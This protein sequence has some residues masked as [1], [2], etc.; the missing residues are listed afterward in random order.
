MADPQEAPL[1]AVRG[2]PLPAADEPKTLAVNPQTGEI[3]GVLDPTAGISNCPIAERE[4]AILTAPVDPEHEMEVKYDG[5]VYMP[6]ACLRKRLLDAFGPG[7]WAMKLESPI[8]YDRETSEIVVDYSLWIKG[9]Y[10]SRA[11]AGWTWNPANPRMAKSDSIESAQ[12]EC[13]R[14]LCKN[15]GVGLELWMPGV[16][17]AWR[18]KY[19][20]S[21]KDTKG[22][23][24]WKR[25]DVAAT[26]RS[27]ELKN[28]LGA[29]FDAD[30]RPAT[31][32]EVASAT[33]GGAAEEK[34]GAVSTRGREDAPGGPDNAAPPSAEPVCP[35]CN[36][37][38]WDNRAKRAEAEAAIAAG[39][40]ELNAKGKP[41]AA[42]PGWKCKDKA[43][44]G[45]I[46]TA[47]PE[48][49]SGAAGIVPT[50]DARPDVDGRPE[51]SPATPDLP[52]Q[53]SQ[54]QIDKLHAIYEK[55]G[56]KGPQ[57]LKIIGSRFKIPAKIVH[58]W[59]KAHPK[60]SI[61][62]I[63]TAEQADALIASYAPMEAKTEDVS[64]LIADIENWMFDGKIS[65]E[66]VDEKCTE[67]GIGHP[68]Q[69]SP[70]N[71]IRLL[72]EKCAI[73]AKDGKWK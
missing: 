49:K 22:R 37:P 25:K 68:W 17:N 32:P 51:P 41:K 62:G 46:W 8:V 56:L 29:R 38:M 7:R 69:K 52:S 35:K 18:D 12:T 1:P 57:V 70:A 30:A 9:C 31:G 36:G 43:C 64:A 67:L 21:Y 14:R 16:A 39:T 24:A 44:K 6:G 58:E 63:L 53:V 48:A 23:T 15:L 65:V 19:A 47:V 13:L 42:P 26:K 3:V 72:W 11:Q 20:V 54:P 34:T 50:P 28:E 61:L 2:A 33:V 40:R 10:I 27:E 5:M 45:V 55:A 71:A 59:I 73:S 60:D 4:A 66:A